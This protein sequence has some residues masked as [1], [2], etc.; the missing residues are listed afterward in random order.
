MHEDCMSIAEWGERQIAAPQTFQLSRILK[1]TS[2]PSRILD[3]V[4]HMALLVGRQ[5]YLERVVPFTARDEM[6]LNLIHVRGE[7]EP[8]K[9]PILLVHGA[10]VRANLFGAPVETNLVDALIE[11]GYDVW[12]EN[13][14]ASIDLPPNLWT[15]DQAAAHDHPAAVEK[16]IAETGAANIKALIHCQGSTSFMMSAIAGLVPQVDLI[17][18]NAVSLHPVVPRWSKFKLN[19]AVPSVRLLTQYFDPH[20]GVCA[21]GLIPKFLTS[22]VRLSHHECNNTVCKMVSFTY[23]SGFPALWR[24]EN[25]NDATHE[26][27]KEEFGPVPLRFFQQMA[28]CVRRGHLVALESV[29]GMPNDYTAHTPKTDARFVFMAGEKS[30]CFLPE[31]QIKTHAYFEALLP[32]DKQGQNYHTLHLWP[33]YSHLDVLIGKDA[34]R[35]VFPTILAELERGAA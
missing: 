34:A 33:N 9:G 17:I 27:L 20:W 5:P 22:L 28:Q 11:A 7:S 30:G 2:F 21:P 15:L 26:W 32:F 3:Q 31:S 12:L 25:L 13:W 29:S 35:D 1:D 18:S 16:V 10:G 24:H 4:H 8:T 19:Y 14:R 6:P 23:G